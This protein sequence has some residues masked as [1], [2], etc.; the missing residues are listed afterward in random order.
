MASG[1]RGASIRS[2]PTCSPTLPG[3]G[4]AS[5]S[6]FAPSGIGDVAHIS[7]S[8]QGIGIALD[9]QA[10]IF[11]RFVRAVPGTKYGGLGLG[12]YISRQIVEALGGSIGVTSQPGQGATF[13]VELPMAL[14]AG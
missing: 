3:S 7:V 4:P 11:D 9:L 6:R 12:L 10:H 5:P 2:C 14:P 8:D 13:T 1:T